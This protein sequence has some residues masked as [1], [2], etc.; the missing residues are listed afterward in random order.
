MDLL[1]LVSPIIIVVYL[2]LGFVPNLDA[3]DK[4]APQWLGMTLLNFVSLFVLIYKRKSIKGNITNVL[5]PY[6]SIFYLGFIFWAGLSYFYAINN[7]EVLVNLTRQ[8]NVLLMYLFMG[9]F[10]SYVNKRI[11]FISWVLTII[12]SIEIYY[13]LDQVIDLINT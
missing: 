12:L 2:C 8:V 13:V 1:K 4:I 9:I 7:T 10:L 5:T 11:F 6:I 3:V